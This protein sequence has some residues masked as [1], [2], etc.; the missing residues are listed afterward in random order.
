M[1]SI[2]RISYDLFDTF[3]LFAF[4][5]Y[6]YT[7]YVFKKLLPRPPKSLEGEI[8]LVTGSGRGIGRFICLEL[9]SHGATVVCWS[10]SPGPNEE[11]AQQIRQRGGKAF[12]YSVD[13]GDKKAVEQSANLVKKEV[14][15]VTIVINNAGVMKI[16]PFLDT[17]ETDVE[18]MFSVNILSHIWV[19]KQFL[20]KML[21][22]NKGHLVSVCSAAGL[23][24]TRNLVSYSSTKHAVHGLYDALRDELR[25]R[26]DNK[27]KITSVYPFYCSTAML[28]GGIPHT[29]FPFL[30][31]ID[32]PEVVAAKIVEGIRSEVEYL[33]TPRLVGGL[34][35]NVFMDC[36]VESSRCVW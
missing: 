18:S 11:V 15:N 10:K 28:D 12:A 7:E 34:A 21:E 19:I 6:T 24:P 2:Q 5:L 9:A 20:P 27:V 14:G 26:N 17:S 32:P 23:L 29:R 33:Y 25:M 30:F 35:G 8:I 4:H 22:V 31:P 1:L 16:S 13:V 36:P 3:R